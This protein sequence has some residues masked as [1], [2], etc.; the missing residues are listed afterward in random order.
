MTT[1][2]QP[3]DI[4][5]LALSVAGGGV[6]IALFLIVSLQR[7]WKQIVD[8]PAPPPNTL[9]AIDP[10]LALYALLAVPFI[11]SY[12]AQVGEP[13]TTQPADDA[14]P[15]AMTPTGALLQAV[16][17]CIV[18]GVLLGIGRFRFQGSLRAWGL[19]TDRLG[20][21]LMWAVIGYVA[22]WPIC[23]LLLYASRM[24]IAWLDPDFAFDPHPTIVSLRA[25]APV[26][27]MA[28]ISI[29]TVALKPIVEELCFR[30]L[31]LTTLLHFMRSRWLAVL[32]GGA[33][34]G[35]F[36]FSLAETVL[37][38]VAFGIVLCYAYA[39]THSLTLVI[40]MHAIFNAKT[41][42]WLALGAE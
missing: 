1:A 20:R 34:F 27:A 38:L 21:D 36:H 4:A 32:L 29:T 28:V 23:K 33:L 22:I 30:G 42:L 10:A 39:R 18:I 3:L 2:L 25:T 14:A 9:Q 26:W 6:L 40:L 13:A 19:R 11:L 17:A 16:A 35:L 15:A 31:L 7:R 37:P 8:L 41:L 12:V 5:E 24:V